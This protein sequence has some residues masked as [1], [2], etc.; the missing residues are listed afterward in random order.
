MVSALETLSEPRLT[1]LRIAVAYTSLAGIRLLL[2]R[3]KLRAG[4]AWATVPKIVVT[5]LDFGLT[6]PRALQAIAW[7][8]ASGKLGTTYRVG[9]ATE[10]TCGVF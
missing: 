7:R 6:D 1:G 10:R 9:N 3:L 2:P 5:S 8:Y 4:A